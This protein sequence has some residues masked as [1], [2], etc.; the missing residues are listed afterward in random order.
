MTVSPTAIIAG[1]AAVGAEAVRAPQAV[2]RD[3]PAD[4]PRREDAHQPQS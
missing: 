3:E 1:D 2:P 4:L